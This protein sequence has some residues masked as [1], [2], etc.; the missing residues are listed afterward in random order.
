MNTKTTAAR[1]AIDSTGTKFQLPESFPILGERNFLRQMNS[2][3]TNLDDAI[4]ALVLTIEDVLLNG[5]TVSA[6]E[7]AIIWQD[8]EVAFFEAKGRD[9]REEIGLAEMHDQGEAHKAQEIQV[10]TLTKDEQ[11]QIQDLIQRHPFENRGYDAYRAAFYG[12]CSSRRSGITCVVWTRRM[13]ERTKFW[14][15][16]NNAAEYYGFVLYVAFRAWTMPVDQLA[17]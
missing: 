14:K 9:W 6:E 17:R 15:S 13:M 10:Q 16:Q 4:R 1:F 3:E 12:A 5:S 8:A 7:L 11:A 2:D